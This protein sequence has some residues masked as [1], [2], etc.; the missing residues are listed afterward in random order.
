VYSLKDV[1][2]KAIED[3]QVLVI[4]GHSR[5][6][7]LRQERCQIQERSHVIDDGSTLERPNVLKINI[8]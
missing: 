5:R 6:D 4:V 1:M 7:G 8:T 2:L 3:K